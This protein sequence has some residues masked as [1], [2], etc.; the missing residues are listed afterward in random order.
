MREMGRWVPIMVG[1]RNVIGEA[2]WL[3]SEQN[4]YARMYHPVAKPQRVLVEA[5]SGLFPVNT[6]CLE[7]EYT[8]L[9]VRLS[10][11]WRGGNAGH[12]WVWGQVSR[13]QARPLVA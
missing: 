3:D 6:E 1:T 13:C 4:I 10:D 12:A 9:K 2:N 7:V 11:R 8:E 5:D